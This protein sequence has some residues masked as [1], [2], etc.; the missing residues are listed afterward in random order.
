MPPRTSPHPDNY[1][2]GR[3]IVS[4]AVW[5]GSVVGSYTDVGACPRFEFEMTEQALEHFISRQAM[6]M[7]DA[8]IVLQSGYNLNFTLDEISVFNMQMFLKGALSGTRILYA[9]KDTGRYYAI[10][11]VSDNAAGPNYVAEFWKCKLSPNGAFSLIGDDWATLSFSGKGL[12]DL[13]NHNE[14]PY[15]TFTY[16]T[17]TTTTSSSTTTTTAP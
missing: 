15:Q 11:F 9:N 4:I 6:K 10:K 17:T 7:Q 14:S 12:A 8:E 2:V 1:V 16:D 3:G 5:T 13:V